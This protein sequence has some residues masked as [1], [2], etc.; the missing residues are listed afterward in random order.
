MYTALFIIFLVWRKHNERI[1]VKKGSFFHDT[2][3]TLAET[4]KVVYWWSVKNTVLQTSRE[5]GIS[6]QT[7]VE[8]FQFLREMCAEVV[9]ANRQPIGGFDDKGQPRICEIDESKFG[10]MKYHR[11]RLIF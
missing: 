3:L 10:Q 7:L 5:T 8:Y 4:V 1:S 11:V 2:N 6:Q 9:Y